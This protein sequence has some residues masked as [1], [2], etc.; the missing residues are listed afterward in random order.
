MWDDLVE[1]G[2]PW[3]RVGLLA[4]I[5]LLGS[6]VPVPFER[7]PE[8]ERFGPDKALH[9][10]GHGALAA[11]IVDALGT[12]G[13]DTRLA[14]PIAVGGSTVLGLLTGRLQERVPGRAPEIADVVAGL[15]GSV[16]GVL[17]WAFLRSGGSD[18][19]G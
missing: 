7:R 1:S 10:L 11:S 19:G 2:S 8:F 12:D 5:V 18:D 9:L 14:G 6:L 15:V 16:L 4:A 13:V 17:G 3:R